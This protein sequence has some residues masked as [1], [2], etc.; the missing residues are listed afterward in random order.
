VV[1][2]KRSP[3]PSLPGDTDMHVAV[4]ADRLLQAVRNALA[5]EDWGGL[6]VSH[7]RVLS[8]VPTSGT[9]ITTLSGQLGMTKQAVGQFVNHLKGTGHLEVGTDAKDRRRHLVVRTAL[10]DDTIER[11][12]AVVS[13]LEHEW[14]QQVGAE[15][16]REFRCVLAEIAAV[17]PQ[18]GRPRP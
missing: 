8:V 9:P 6:R 15:R 1:D 11:V 12:N 13:G 4:L 10:G 3:L 7:F 2:V 17:S 14:S 5:L 18:S 16:Y